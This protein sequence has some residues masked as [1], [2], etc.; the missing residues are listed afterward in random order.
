MEYADVFDLDGLI[1]R[2]EYFSIS[3]LGKGAGS[4]VAGQAAK[5]AAE[6]AAKDAAEKAAKDAAEKAAK[7]A[8][9]K[10]AKDAA[11]K[12]AKDAAEK[13]AKDAAEQSAKDAAEKSAKDAAEKAGKDYA[14]YAAAAAAAGLGLYL[15]GSSADAADQSNNTPR[16]ITKISP[17]GDSDT[18][19]RIDFDPAIK[20]LLADSIKFQSSNTTPSVDGPQ[21]VASVIS[22][23]AITVDFGTSLDQYGPG[24][25]IKVTTSVGSQAEDTVT[26]GAASVGSAV[27]GAAGGAAGGLFGGLSKGL[28]ISTSTLKKIG[29]ALAVVCCLIIV[30]LIVSSA[31][32]MTPKVPG[33]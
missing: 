7:D 11:E 3:G 6:K 17:S 20:I 26:Q 1:G 13:S 29:I 30:G 12:A 33:S 4:D 18:A 25:T 2:H 19:Y 32:K 8:A 23:S 31:S 5:D 9:E 14:Q 15:Y 10:A 28:G 22:D 24:G 21:S 27:G 16:G